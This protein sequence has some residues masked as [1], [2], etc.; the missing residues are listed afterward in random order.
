M[1]VSG[2]WGDRKEGVKETP[3]GALTDGGADADGIDGVV[4]ATEGGGVICCKWAGT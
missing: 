4:Y 1:L 3:G 2:G